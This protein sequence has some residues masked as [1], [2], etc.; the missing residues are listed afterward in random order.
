MDLLLNS[1]LTCHRGLIDMLAVVSPSR[2]WACWGCWAVRRVPVGHLCWKAAEFTSWL[3]A[4]LGYIPRTTLGF[5]LFFFYLLSGWIIIPNE[6]RGKGNKVTIFCN[7]LM[8]KLLGYPG[9]WVESL[10]DHFSPA[11]SCCS[12]VLQAI[13]HY[14][15]GN[16]HH[17]TEDG[18]DACFTLLLQS[19]RFCA[20]ICIWIRWHFQLKICKFSK[21]LWSNA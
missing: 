2:I 7:L 19:P 16:W 10:V 5:S 20:N 3:V 14:F 13:A 1:A 17:L 21:F 11:T 15:G 4:F 8:Y 6:T 9:F 12:H 18:G